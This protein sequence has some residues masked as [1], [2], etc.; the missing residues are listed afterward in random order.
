MVQ[1][2]VAAFVS[3]GR[4]VRLRPVTTDGAV[5]ALDLLGAS[6]ADLA[7]G[8]GDLEMPADAQTIAIVRKNF[9]ALW[10]PSGLA[11][12]KK[13]RAENQGDQGSRGA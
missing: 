1:A 5:E 4:T 2:M 8:R 11:G 12:Q 13:A 6:K 7:V 9:V 3:E 10:A